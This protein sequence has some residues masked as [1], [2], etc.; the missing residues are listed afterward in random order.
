MRGRSMSGPNVLTEGA[1][2]P[3]SGRVPGRDVE[4]YEWDHP[5]LGRRETTVT[6]RLA[7]IAT[8]ARVTLRHEGFGRS[9][10]AYEHAE[11]WERFLGW[12]HAYMR[13]D[14][15]SAVTQS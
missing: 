10:P 2:K 6:Y 11:G 1:F 12:L 14:S 8:G 9:E 3:F 15:A 7:P 4:L 5:L 13:P